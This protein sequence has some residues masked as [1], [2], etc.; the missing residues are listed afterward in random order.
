[1]DIL[2]PEN[3]ITMKTSLSLQAEADVRASQADYEMQLEKVRSA[4][5]KIVQTHTSHQGHLRTLMPA[6][7]AFFAECL[8]HLGELEREP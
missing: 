5:K 7:R 8:A 2:Y 1:M 6:Q 4:M 3:Y